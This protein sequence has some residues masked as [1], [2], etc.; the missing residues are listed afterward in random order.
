MTAP[1]C[2]DVVHTRI[3]HDRAFAEAYSSSCGIQYLDAEPVY[4]YRQ[5]LRCGAGLACDLPAET[6]VAA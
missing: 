4:E 6:G 3:K 5:C 1:F 2:P